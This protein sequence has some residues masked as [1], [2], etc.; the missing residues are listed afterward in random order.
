MFPLSISTA[1][2]GILEKF[3]TSVA[4]FGGQ[5]VMVL[6]VIIAGLFGVMAGWWSANT[7]FVA[8]IIAPAVMGLLTLLL[9]AK[10]PQK[11][12]A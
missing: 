11:D 7:V 3:A 12:E 8:S 9:L 2:S 6:C 5:I 1:K 10:L 4:S